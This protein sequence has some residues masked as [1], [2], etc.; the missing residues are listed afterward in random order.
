MQSMFEKRGNYGAKIT[1]NKPDYSKL[2]QNVQLRYSDFN[3][4]QISLPFEGNK[5]N[6]WWFQKHPGL[7]ISIDH[8]VLK[9]ISVCSMMFKVSSVQVYGLQIIMEF[10]GKKDLLGRDVCSKKGKLC[11]QTVDVS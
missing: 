10:T 4:I 9:I 2:V 5:N 1:S 8:H 6:I 7:Q 3:Y 11:S